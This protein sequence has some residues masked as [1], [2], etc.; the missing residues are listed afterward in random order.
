MLFVIEE[1]NKCLSI[2]DKIK[3]ETNYYNNE[4]NK[5]KIENNLKIKEKHEQ[6]KNDIFVKNKNIKKINEELLLPNEIEKIKEKKLKKT[7]NEFWA[8]NKQKLLKYSLSDINMN[9]KTI[10]NK[11]KIL[12][13]DVNKNNNINEKLSVNQ[14]YSK[15]KI[16][17]SNL[18][19]LNLK[20]GTI[21]EEHKLLPLFNL[22]TKKILS[23]ILPLSEIEKYEKRYE[24]GRA[25][26]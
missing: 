5:L 20:L 7:I 18:N 22:Q 14:L 4:L 12:K 13:T 19:N 23:K 17:S 10:K 1:H 8:L 16:F 9:I 15:K 2:Q 11:N 24:I 25:H 3:K 6:Y 21:D 26:V